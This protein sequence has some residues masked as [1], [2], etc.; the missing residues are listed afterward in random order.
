VT[1][2]AGSDAAAA[3]ALHRVAHERCFIA[4]SVNF[5]VEHQPSIEV[6]TDG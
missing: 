3:L 2:A 4:R 5:P 1:L 6:L